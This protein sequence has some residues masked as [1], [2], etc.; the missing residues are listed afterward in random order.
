MNVLA[1][2]GSMMSGGM[3]PSI[4]M[5][6]LKETVS[7]EIGT[8]TEK[9]E[10]WVDPIKEAIDIR[11]QVGDEHR[12]YP[13]NNSMLMPIIRGALQ[14]YAG[15]LLNDGDE[16]HMIALKV[17]GKSAIGEL[18]YENARG[19]DCITQKFDA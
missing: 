11:V 16:I 3:S 12:K 19:K 13:V 18:Y 14:R 7:T 9:F 10:V 2:L 8:P 4:A 17:D 1:Q 5:K 15:N 6:Y